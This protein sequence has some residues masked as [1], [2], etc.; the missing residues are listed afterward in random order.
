VGER[1]IRTFVND[2]AGT[3]LSSNFYWTNPDVVSVW[4][5]G[6]KTNRGTNRP[7]TWADHKALRTALK[8][9]SANPVAPVELDVRAVPAAGSEPGWAGVQVTL[10]NPSASPS[11]LTRIKGVDE[12]GEQILP[13]IV[14]D[15]Y[16]TLMPGE[17]VTL[18]AKYKVSGRAGAVTRVA[19][20]GFNAADQTVSL[21]TASAGQSGQL[22]ALVTVA[23]GLPRGTTPQ[24]AWSAFAGA[25]AA[26]QAV[27]GTP[28][29]SQVEIDQAQADLR[30]AIADL[31]LPAPADLSGLAGAID[32]ASA[33]G[34]EGFTPASWQGVA[35]ALAAARAVAG[36]SYPVQEAADGAARDLLAAV[37][38][39]ETVPA[40]DAASQKAALSAVIDVVEAAVGAEGG[41]TAESWAPYAEA[42]DAARAALTDPASTPARVTAAQAA[43]TSAFASLVRVRSAPANSALLAALIETAQGRLAADYTP[44]TWSALAQGLAH[45]RAVAA[46]PAASEAEIA[47]AIV[48]LSRA[49]SGLAR[50]E[51]GST[52]IVPIAS[53]LVRVKAGQGSIVLVRGKTATVAALGYDS[54][55]AASKSVRWTTSNSKV[56]KVNKTTGKLR[57]VGAGKATVKAAS[58]L[59]NANGKYV[60]ATVKVTVVAPEKSRKATKVTANVPKTLK[61]GA[62]KGIVPKVAPASATGA[63]VA[64]TSS[65]PS[66]LKVDKAGTLTGVKAGQATV[67]VKAGGRTAKYKVQVG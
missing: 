33:L 19:V 44:E 24:A 9:T 46:N 32:R 11:L 30:W 66:V 10:T 31:Q 65:R 25:L 43:V 16:V 8:G 67:T 48:A 17:T 56:V 40:V 64:Y 38:G 28:G 58:A 12:N 27:L 4:P 20:D 59:P 3:E 22:A 54:T 39:L 34:P 37:A 63:K 13:F 1:F 47:Q 2:G 45:A 41:Y 55:G 42:L 21:G 18:S 49:E 36:S 51:P 26:A 57:A 29:A 35:A 15:N 62:T 60:S 5:E 14:D 7:T 50:I 52:E 53:A 23:E 6:S 61:V